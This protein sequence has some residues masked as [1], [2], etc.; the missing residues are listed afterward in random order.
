[1]DKMKDSQVWSLN[2]KTWTWELERP[3]WDRNGRR[4]FCW[5]IMLVIVGIILVLI[6]I[7]AIQISPSYFFEYKYRTE[8]NSRSKQTIGRYRYRTVQNSSFKQISE[9]T[10]RK[11]SRLLWCCSQYWFKAKGRP[12][13]ILTIVQWITLS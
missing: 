2:T 3:S 10:D 9:L 12:S 8:Q 11:S 4:W 13:N 6:F 1:M 5:K 7:L